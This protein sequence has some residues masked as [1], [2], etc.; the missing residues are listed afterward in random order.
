MEKR[1]ALIQFPKMGNG[2]GARINLSIPLLKKIGFNQENREV[3]IIYDEE[4][5]K[6]II[7]KRK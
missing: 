7:Q 2:K 6:I 3:E 4:N 1:E 5:Q